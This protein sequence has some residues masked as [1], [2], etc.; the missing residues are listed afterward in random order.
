MVLS[1][2]TQLK[3]HQILHGVS[4]HRSGLA[5]HVFFLRFPFRA[6][7]SGAVWG[8]LGTGADW[9]RN[10]SHGL[11]GVLR[12]RLFARGGDRMHAH[13]QKSLGLICFELCLR[14]KTQRAPCRTAKNLNWHYVGLKSH[15]LH[16]SHNTPM[17]THAQRKSYSLAKR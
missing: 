15:Q 16:E 2:F 3:T 9:D 6:E 7:R 11:H 12:L 5:V 4:S 1:G 8:T 10:F 13:H 14:S 17:E